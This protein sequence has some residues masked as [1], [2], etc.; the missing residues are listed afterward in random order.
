MV[1]SVGQQGGFV[2]RLQLND[3]S[4]T[5]TAQAR[6]DKQTDAAASLSQ[7]ISAALKQA[8]VGGD[9][10]LTKDTRI[11][12]DL[13]PEALQ[14]RLTLPVAVGNRPPAALGVT[15]T[16]DSSGAYTLGALIQ[17]IGVACC[18]SSCSLLENKID[19]SSPPVKVLG[20][21]F[22]EFTDFLNGT[23]SSGAAAL[24]SKLDVW[25]AKERSR[26][27]TSHDG[28]VQ[29]ANGK[30]FV[31]GKEVSLQDLFFAARMNQLGEVDRGLQ[32]YFNEI[33][34][35]NLKAKEGDY[36]VSLLR[37]EGLNPGESIGYSAVAAL[38]N[39][40]SSSYGYDPLKK[41]L[42]GTTLPA[43]ASVRATQRY[44]ATTVGGWIEQAKGWVVD[45][46]ADNQIAQLKL[47]KLNSKRNE[48]LEGVT[49]FTKSQ[50]QLGQSVARNM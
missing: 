50:T 29:V 9:A 11:P 24:S 28:G 16:A 45:R 14:D 32:G 15:F 30:I 26:L 2:T 8:R 40:F 34:E 33:A 19:N 22:P 25:A 5:E 39:K 43:D 38:V 36:F 31:G 17:A 3:T 13:L 18:G 41:F 21:A 7:L 20:D 42:P 44:D 23:S 37:R 10:S 46:G 27:S 47:E 12:L 1:S 35:N 48:I 4:L 6:L 49:T